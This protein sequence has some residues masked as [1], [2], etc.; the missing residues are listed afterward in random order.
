MNLYSLDLKKSM[1][2]V[3]EK[4]YYGISVKGYELR[5][6]SNDQL[7]AWINE[8]INCDDNEEKD[9]ARWYVT[10]KEMGANLY[11]LFFNGKPLGEIGFLEN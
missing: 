3:A 7:G 11:T 1:V 6:V 4:I 5:K 8:K 9:L 10:M 2:A